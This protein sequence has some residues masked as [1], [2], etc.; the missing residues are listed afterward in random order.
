MTR[1]IT[2]IC[3]PIRDPNPAVVRRN[4]ARAVEAARWLESHGVPVICVHAT[5]DAANAMEPME[6]WIDRDLRLIEVCG[7]MLMLPGWRNSEGCEA[8]YAWAM[9]EGVECYDAQEFAERLGILRP[10]EEFLQ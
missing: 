4:L 10:S 7:A 1:P 2:Y 3:G 9:G 5:I 8:E 6:R